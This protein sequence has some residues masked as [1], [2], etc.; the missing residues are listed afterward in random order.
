M[1]RERNVNAGQLR[2]RPNHLAEIIRMVE[3]KKITSS[4]GKDLL[5]RVE[6]TGIDPKEMVE[7]EGLAQVSDEDTLK[8]LVKEV[9]ASNPEQ[10]AIYKGGKTTLLG[11][12]VGQIMRET[13]GKADAQLTKAILEEFLND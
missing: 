8:S 3:E 5:D 4:T 1:I 6:E 7:K 2:I 10:V 11:W 9:I 13:K 12:F